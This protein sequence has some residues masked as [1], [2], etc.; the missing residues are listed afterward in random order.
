MKFLISHTFE[1]ASAR[2]DMVLINPFCN[3]KSS[4]SSIDA[5]NDTITSVIALSEPGKVFA[6]SNNAGIIDASTDWFNRHDLAN[7]LSRGMITSL[8]RTNLCQIWVYVDSMG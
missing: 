6:I 3:F 5:A 2:V 1:F 7:S 8:V 4:K